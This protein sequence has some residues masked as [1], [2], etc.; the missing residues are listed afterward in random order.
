MVVQ[1]NEYFLYASPL[2]F[3]K[4]TLD[5]ILPIILSKIESDGA[6]KLK[7]ML[8]VGI[9]FKFSKRSPGAIIATYNSLVKM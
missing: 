7:N 5:G 1:N 4:I 2:E 3:L 6:L 8:L 9:H